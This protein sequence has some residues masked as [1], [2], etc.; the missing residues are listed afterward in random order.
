MLTR[1][2]LCCFL[3]G[4]GKITFVGL[5]EDGTRRIGVEMDKPAGETV[6]VRGATMPV[7]DATARDPLQLTLSGGRVETDAD[8]ASVHSG[9]ELYVPRTTR[10]QW[11][12][13][14]TTPTFQAVST[15]LPLPAI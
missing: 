14:T 9:S 10:A 13:F 8:P 2:V 1:T 15:V 5:A 6:Q 4:R 7:V 12:S 11:K 3:K